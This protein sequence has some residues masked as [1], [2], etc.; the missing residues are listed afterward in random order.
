MTKASMHPQWRYRRDALNKKSLLDVELLSEN[1]TVNVGIKPQ[2]PVQQQIS[3]PTSI[4]SMPERVPEMKPIVLPGSWIVVGKRGKPIP[5]EAKMYDEPATKSKK[6]KKTKSRPRSGNEKTE[7]IWALEAAPASSKCL[8]DL[9]VNTSRKDKEATRGRLAKY[10]GQY[11]QGKARMAHA[12]D[13]LLASM[14]FDDEVE[15]PE[16]RCGPERMP[17]PRPMK[18]HD[19]KKKSAR[20]RTR[21]SARDAKYWSYHDEE[22]DDASALELDHVPMWSAPAPRTR[23]IIPA[24]SWELVG[25]RGK[26]ISF[27][28]PRKQ[29]RTRTRKEELDL[30]VILEA[31]PM[32]SR[33]LQD[34]YEGAARHEKAAVR[35]RTV[36]YWQHYREQKATK[37]HALNTLLALPMFNETDA[38]ASTKVPVKA[39][40]DDKKVKVNR[41]RARD[42]KFALRFEPYSSNEKNDL[43]AVRLAK[44][45]AM[46]FAYDFGVPSPTS[47]RPACSPGVLVQLTDADLGIQRK[48]TKKSKCSVS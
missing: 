13:S 41:R 1:E 4:F 42:A 28:T 48:H 40:Q 45:Q 29:K 33:C 16:G 34:V 11:R 14:M 37:I 23:P 6:K 8:Q 47:P 44:K 31:N 19:N 22:E 15:A 36:K 27:T 20:E 17:T 26:T 21:R 9:L 3:S 43:D 30:P 5:Q 24:G 7:S 18:V 39:R 10:W 2:P 12:H 32:A 46:A 35:G 25:K 38:P